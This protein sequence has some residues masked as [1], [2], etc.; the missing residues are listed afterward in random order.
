MWK[1]T[2]KIFIKYSRF[3]TLWV[4]ID[5][6]LCL[7]LNQIKLDWFLAVFHQTRYKTFFGLVLKD[8]ET[9]SGMARNNS[10]SLEIIFWIGLS[11]GIVHQSLK[12]DQNCENKSIFLSFW[13]FCLEKSK[14]LISVSD[15]AHKS[16]L[17]TLYNFCIKPKLGKLQNVESWKK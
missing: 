9:D 2:F 17:I 4:P 6:D 13:N 5:S 8:S 11:F 7:R 15:T 10:D 16:L 12:S 3:E 14:I 1:M